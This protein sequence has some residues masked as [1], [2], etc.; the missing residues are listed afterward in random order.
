[1]STRKNNMCPPAKSNDA[2]KP[3]FAHLI[4]VL[5]DQLRH[6]IVLVACPSTPAA[7]RPSALDY[8]AEAGAGPESAAVHERRHPEARVS[9]LHVSGGP[10]TP[11]VVE[12]G[13]GVRRGRSVR[14][15]KITSRGE[16]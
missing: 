5:V 10:D 16:S 1:M 11:S 12:S 8:V 6:G 9:Y 2:S 13:V 3:D 15:V 14:V 7:D 4:A